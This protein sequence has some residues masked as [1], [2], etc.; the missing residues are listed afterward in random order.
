MKPRPSNSTPAMSSP[1][2]A[3][4][5]MRPAAT[6]KWLPSIVR[7]PA[8]VRTAMLTALPDW[9]LALRSSV[10]NVALDAFVGAEFAGSR[11]RRR[12]PPALMS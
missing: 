9:P 5:G 4:F 12:G 3:V 10:G 7:S 6:R 2:P 11:A 8:F 1:I